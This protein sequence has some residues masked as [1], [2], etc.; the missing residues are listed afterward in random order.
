MTAPATVD[1]QKLNS[2]LWRYRPLLD[3]FEFLLEMQLMV[4]ASGRQGWQHHMAE[5]FE[6]TAD[7]LNALDLEREM[8]LGGGHPLGNIV[9]DAPEPW[10]EILR[11][12]AA[13]L[14]SASARVGDLR[15]RNEVAISEGLAGLQGLMEALLAAS[16][17]AQDN[18]GPSYG[19]DGQLR[20]DTGAAVLFDGRV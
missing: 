16:Q 7:A 18:A 5:L 17:S 1:Y 12:Q 20:H 11:E 6:E 10:D 19:E 3:R 13:A 15:R 14:T 2:M 9:A 4:S 8:F